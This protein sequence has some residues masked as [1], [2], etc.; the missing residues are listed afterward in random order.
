MHKVSYLGPFGATFSHEAY[1][2]FARA[3]RAPE[4]TETNYVSVRTNAEV[5]DS[6]I[7]NDGY[8]VLTTET[9]A[10]CRINQSIESFARLLEHHESADA[11]PFHIVGAAV[12]PVTFSLMMYGAP[13][14]SGVQV[15]YGHEE[16]LGACAR[17]L[18]RQNIVQR[19]VSSNGEAARI[20]AEDRG[21]L[22]IAAVGPRIA[23]EQ[24]RLQVINQGIEDE[25]AATIFVWLAPRAHPV[26][27]GVHNRAIIAFRV[28][29]EPGALLRV[30]EPFAK[31]GVNLTSIHSVPL[32]QGIYSFVIEVDVPCALGTAYHAVLEEIRRHTTR[33]IAFGPFEVLDPAT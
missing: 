7:L 26:R 31:R 2:R 25:E 19:P 6:V 28:P 13:R 8:G 23:A 21:A 9:L 32:R 17:Y 27:V 3:R 18:S 20:V 4:A 22:P 5:L 10:H 33:C 14:R 12:E 15:A 30:Q 1:R 16:A 11:L 24:Y 29:H